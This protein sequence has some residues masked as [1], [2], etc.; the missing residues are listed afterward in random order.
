M[1][2]AEILLGVR[3]EHFEVVAPEKGQ[4]DLKVDHVEILGADTLV[5]GH[6]GQDRAELTVRLPDVHHFKNG[7]TLPLA[8]EA[9]R[10]HLFDP[11]SG[12]RLTT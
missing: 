3:P 5:Y 4:L 7:T 6:C 10:L 2:D 11:Q 8:V 12:R 9:S 1:V